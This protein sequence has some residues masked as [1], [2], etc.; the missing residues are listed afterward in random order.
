MAVPRAGQ[1]GG[2]MGMGVHIVAEIRVRDPLAEMSAVMRRTFDDLGPRRGHE[3]QD[4]WTWRPAVQGS[5]M[6]LDV[7]E[8]PDGL[9]IE[10]PLPGF[11]KDEVKVTLEKG[12]LSIRAEHADDRKEEKGAQAHTYFLRERFRGTVARSVLVGDTYD[13]DSVTGLLKDGVLTLSIK[14]LA[15]ALPRE[16]TIEALN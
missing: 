12:K 1:V 2:S 5:R 6:P 15:A 14:K 13:P 9:R 11:S 10:A 7:Y 8:T 4:G 16:V 3:G